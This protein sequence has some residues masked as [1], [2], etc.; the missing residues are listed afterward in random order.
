MKQLSFLL[1]CFIL[2]MSTREC[3]AQSKPDSIKKNK[4]L[5]PAEGTGRKYFVGYN[6][7]NEF[8]GGV[9]FPGKSQTKLAIELSYQFAYVK[10]KE[11]GGINFSLSNSCSGIRVRT[12]MVFQENGANYSVALEYQ[13][14]KSTDLYSYE[15]ASSSAPQYYFRESYQNIGMKTY[16]LFPIGNH[17]FFTCSAGFIFKFVHRQYS[18]YGFGPSNLEEDFI[19]FAIQLNAGLRYSF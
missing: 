12:C 9:Q 19:S 1:S 3:T 5:S 11:Y 13:N 2:L 17:L 4:P 14:L 15:S 18:Y 6:T 10:L 8:Y 16:R 7:F